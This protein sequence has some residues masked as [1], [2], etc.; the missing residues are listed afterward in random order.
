MER[1]SLMIKKTI[2][3]LVQTGYWLLY[4]MLLSVLFFL[5]TLFQKPPM[6]AVHWFRIMLGFAIVPGISGFYASY[7]ILFPYYLRT[8]NTLRLVLFFVLAALL[9][10]LIGMITLIVLVNAQFL[11][12]DG[13]TG[14]ITMA[15]P[16]TF[17]AFVNGVTGFILRG[18]LSWLEEI[19]LKEELS[20]KNYEM[21]L[22]L[23]KSRIDPHFLFNTIHNI[24]ILIE[25][26]STKASAY[27]NKLSD[28]MRFM[29]YETKPNRI[30]L[31]KELEYIEK[32]IALQKIR[33]SNHQAISCTLEGDPGQKMVAPM[34]FIP[35]IENAFK[36]TNLKMN[37]ALRI[38]LVVLEREMDFYCDN[39]IEP[40]THAA[41]QPGGLGKQLIERRLALMYPG[42]HHLTITTD[43]QHY[44]VHLSITI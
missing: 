28:I 33:T 15:I 44:K 5:M 42:K 20:Q 23:V 34:L 9:A 10:A 27:L 21:E 8:K 6:G 43:R 40:Q 16:L 1:V 3:P 4:G 24:D 12:N 19:R 38:R 7:I 13:M 36:H 17:I 39:L 29:L 2:S 25:K 31:T 18:F 37:D 14:A 35:F 11:V 26:E 32:Y 41:S 30:P 22:T